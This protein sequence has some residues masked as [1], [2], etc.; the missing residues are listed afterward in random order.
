MTIFPE[1]DI[2]RFLDSH[3]M[4]DNLETL[5]HDDLPTYTFLMRDL[6]VADRLI[7]TTSISLGVFE[8][9]S[10]LDHLLR[11]GSELASLV[12]EDIGLIF[13]RLDLLLEA[14]VLTVL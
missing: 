11:N 2:D 13:I 4:L 12:G 3:M 6:E 8:F 1:S 14:R 9:G 5:D 10:F 7:L